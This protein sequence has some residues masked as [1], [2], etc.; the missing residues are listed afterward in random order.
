MSEEIRS[1]V[2][3]LEGALNAFK[4]A[5]IEDTRIFA[6]YGEYL[7][8]LKLMPLGFDVEVVNKRSYDILL[9]DRIKVEVKTGKHED[10]SSAASFYK[11]EQIK[12]GK[13]D[14]CVFVSYDGL[15]V[16]EMLVFTRHEL[17]EVA[18]RPRGSPIV[19]YPKTNPCILLRYDTLNQYLNSMEGLTKLD[20]ELELNKHPEKFI[21]R[22]DKIK[23]N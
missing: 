16:K 21:N 9:D 13:F 6:I 10:G 1:V 17:E 15:Q 5:G 12:D 23:V 11:G 20:I 3:A 14:Y 8:A 4:S 2:S 19:R 22:W 18:L 7:V